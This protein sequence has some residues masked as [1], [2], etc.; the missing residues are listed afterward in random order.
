[1]NSI[2]CGL[3]ASTLTPINL[4]IL[5]NDTLVFTTNIGMP[6]FNNANDPCFHGS[7][8]VNVFDGTMTFVKDIQRD[9]RLYPKNNP[10][11]SIFKTNFS[12]TQ[13]FTES[14]PISCLLNSLIQI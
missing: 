10:Y 3:P 13:I 14:S 2:F 7:S 1:M 8:T 9:D 5:V 12:Y 6:A 11:K 4:Q